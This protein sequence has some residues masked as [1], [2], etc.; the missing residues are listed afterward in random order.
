[1]PNRNTQNKKLQARLALSINNNNKKNGR[2]RYSKTAHVNSAVPLVTALARLSSSKKSRGP[3][4]P[5]ASKI[6]SNYKSMIMDPFKPSSNGCRLPDPWSFPTETYKLQSFSTLTSVA[7]GSTLGSICFLPHPNISIFD[8]SLFVNGTSQVTYSNYS[9]IASNG[10]ASL[11]TPTLMAGALNTWR[12][13]G[14]GIKVCCTMPESVRTGRI[15][16]VPYPLAQLPGYNALSSTT[17][18]T[19]SLALAQLTGGYAAVGSAILE[20]PGAFVVTCNELADREIVLR[21]KPHSEQVCSFKDAK[22]GVSQVY[23]SGYSES[24][25]IIYGTAGAV[26]GNEC[27]TAAN[28][29][30][31]GWNGWMVVYEGFPNSNSCLL[32]EQVLHLEGTPIVSALSSSGATPLPTHEQTMPKERSSFSRVFDYISNIPLQESITIMENVNNVYQ[33]LKPSGSLRLTNY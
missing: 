26:T 25:E 33:R 22:A 21:F 28:Y 23:A 2:K 17:F 13:V 9:Q 32:F 24:T 4:L 7:S 8:Y 11:S 18:S 1:V 16:F 3:V 20:I 27:D 19:T 14:G 15:Y 12:V 31:S 10:I 6:M 30:C 29:D 5:R